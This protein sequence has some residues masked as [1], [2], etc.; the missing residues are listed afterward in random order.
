MMKL[1]INRKNHK[2]FFEKFSKI[3][4]REIKKIQNKG[5]G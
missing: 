3:S 2:F 1:D 5:N 4:I